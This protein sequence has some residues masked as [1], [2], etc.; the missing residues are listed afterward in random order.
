MPLEQRELIPF[1]K[2]T[3]MVP[4]SLHRFGS[5]PM[6][7]HLQLGLPG[8]RPGDGAPVVKKPSETGVSALPVI[9]AVG[10]KRNPLACPQCGKVCKNT[11][12]LKGHMRSHNAR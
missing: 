11:F 12:G 3:K 7:R 6:P 10:G 9:P 1:N 5:V 2:G 4:S 8:N